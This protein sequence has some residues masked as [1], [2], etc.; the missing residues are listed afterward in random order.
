MSEVKTYTITL[1]DQLFGFVASAID[2]KQRAEGL[3]ATVNAF[4]LIKI[5]DAAKL[6]ADTPT[7]PTAERAPSNG[8]D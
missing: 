5:F 4:R 3:T 7:T 2:Q 8:D 6:A 1:D